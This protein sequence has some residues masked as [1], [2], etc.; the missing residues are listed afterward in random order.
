MRTKELG[1]DNTERKDGRSDNT[2][3]SKTQKFH[4]STTVTLS[5]SFYASL[6]KCLF[7]S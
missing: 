5:V 4:D 1:F 7:L 2:Y 6:N 3:N